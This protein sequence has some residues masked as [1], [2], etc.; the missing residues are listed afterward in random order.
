MC[1]QHLP[2]GYASLGFVYEEGKDLPIGMSMRNYQGIDRT[3]LNCAVCHVSTVRDTPEAKPRIVLGMPA[4][5]FNLFGF[6]K[7]VFDCARDPKFAT[8]YIVAEIARLMSE[9]GEKLGLLD[10]YL[11]YPV[12]VA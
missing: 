10:R 2:G 4:N 12:A 8:E 9:K 3:F 11:V 1:A 6:Q 7:F 5:T